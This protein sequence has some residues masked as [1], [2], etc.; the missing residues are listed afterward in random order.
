MVINII[1]LQNIK[2][3][4]YTENNHAKISTLGKIQIMRAVISPNIISCKRDPLFKLLLSI[5]RI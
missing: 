4:V 1:I 2:T 3:I 5:N